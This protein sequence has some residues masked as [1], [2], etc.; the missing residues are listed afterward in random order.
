MSNVMVCLSY[1]LRTYRT[2]V[3][4][5]GYDLTTYLPYVGSYLCLLRMP[6]LSTQYVLR[7]HRSLV[8]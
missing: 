2:T 3:S 6:Y 7:I 4:R 1:E 5:F 8:I